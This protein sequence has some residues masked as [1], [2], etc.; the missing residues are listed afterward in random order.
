MGKEKLADD[1]VRAAKKAAKKSSKRK[2]QDQKRDADLSAKTPTALEKEI[3]RVKAQHGESASTR[4]QQLRDAK[5]EAERKKQQQQNATA[6][7]RPSH[8]HLCAS[9]MHI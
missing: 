8:Y 7:V 5:R 3:S 2:A 6:A 9:T 4:L 1:P